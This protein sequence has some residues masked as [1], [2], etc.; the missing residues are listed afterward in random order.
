[1]ILNLLIQCSKTIIATYLTSRTPDITNYAGVKA[2]IVP[3][4]GKHL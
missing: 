2:K 3:K 4:Y 1:M